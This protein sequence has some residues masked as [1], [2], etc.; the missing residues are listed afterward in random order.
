MRAQGAELLAISVDDVSGAQRMQ[1][2]VGASYP[3]LADPTRAT[4][5]AYGVFVLLGDGVAA[6]ATIL[7]DSERLV[8]IQV[9]RNISDRPS[10]ASILDALRQ[11]N[12]GEEAPGLQSG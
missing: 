5:E 7:A 1:Q 6:P 11:Y 10:A 3:V 2:T 9:G 8:A 4:S 12:D